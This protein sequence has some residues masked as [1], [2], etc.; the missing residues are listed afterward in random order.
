MLQE[1]SSSTNLGYKFQLTW[2]YQ[3]HWIQ[4]MHTNPI[5]LNQNNI[6]TGQQPN[7]AQ[8]CKSETFQ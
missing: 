8:N 4:F 3:K 7:L 2:K 1:A 6:R 5:E